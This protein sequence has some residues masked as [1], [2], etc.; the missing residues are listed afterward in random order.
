MP[1]QGCKVSDFSLPEGNVRKHF[2][3]FELIFLQRQFEKPRYVF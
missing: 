1:Q 2:P 3:G